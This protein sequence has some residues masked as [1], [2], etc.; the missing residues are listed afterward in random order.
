MLHFIK[1]IRNATAH[2]KDSGE[3]LESEDYLSKNVTYRDF[4]PSVE[5]DMHEDVFDTADENSSCESSSDQKV[6]PVGRGG[7]TSMP[8]RQKKKQ[9]NIAQPKNKV[10]MALNDNVSYVFQ[11]FEGALSNKENH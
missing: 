6:E 11:K 4:G 9:Y 2:A 10:R 7:P 1:K 8:D 3:C 5:A